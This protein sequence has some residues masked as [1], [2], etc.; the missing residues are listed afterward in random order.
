VCGEGP[1]G[2]VEVDT[3]ADDLGI[4]LFKLRQFLL[5]PNK[6]SFSA[7]REGRRIEGDHEVL[8]ALEVLKADL[9]PPLTEGDIGN[10]VPR[11]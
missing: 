5:E 2:R 11:L 7:A 10:R 6:F 9:L 8:L 1:L 4:E 3:G